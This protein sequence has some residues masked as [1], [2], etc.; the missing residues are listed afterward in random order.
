MS[1]IKLLADFSKAAYNITHKFH[2]ED[3]TINDPS[4]HSAEAFND[5]LKQGWAPLKFTTLSPSINS[6]GYINFGMTDDGMFI[7]GNAAVFAAR[8]GDSIVL[9]F[10]G[11]NDAAKEGENPYDP[12]DLK[13]PD[14]DQWKK[15]PDYYNALKP[16]LTQFDNY[17]KTNNIKN[18]YVTGHSM[19]GAM[20]IEYMSEHSG[21]QYQAVTFAA[22]P[23]GQPYLIFGTER[24]YYTNDDRITQ[25]EIAN[26]PGPMAYDIQNLFGNTRIRP[27]HV[28]EIQGNY[29]MDKPDKTEVPFTSDFYARNPN[30][31]MDYYR[32]ISQSIEDTTWNI[33][34]NSPGKQAV[35][36]GAQEINK[37]FIVDGKISGTNQIIDAGN[38]VLE[39]KYGANVIY[40][41]R[42]DDQIIGDQHAEYILAGD[43]NDT[44]SGNGGNDI[45]FGGLGNDIMDF[46]SNARTGNDT[47]YGG[48]GDDIFVFD[49]PKDQFIEYYNE[50]NDTA[51]VNFDYSLLYTPDIENLRGY[52]ASGVKLFGNSLDNLLSGTNGNDVLEGGAGKD[53]VELNG[54]ISDYK[55]TRTGNTISLLNKKTNEGIDTLINIESLKFADVSSNLEIQALAKTINQKSVNQILELYIAFFNRIPE[56][57]GVAYWLG[58]FKKGSTINQIAESFYNAGLSFSN[59]T[60]YSATMPN[61]DFVKVVYK[62]VLGRSDGGDA[63]GVAYWSEQLS[64]QKASRGSLVSDM[65]N[66]AHGFKNDAKWGWVANL[67]DN[68]V[69]VAKTIAI[70]F[71]INYSSSEAAIRSGMTIAS[72]ITDTDIN[73]ALS[74][75]GVSSLDV[76]L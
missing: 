15:M 33:L 44:I 32:Q 56:A 20:A 45:V 37:Q 41:G 7:N 3:P 4:P 12:L 74:I 49:S 72:Y 59:L 25:I 69:T 75:I 54:K 24:K 67:L 11:T 39:S 31:S 55:I 52:G 26:D 8:Q 10:R 61:S 43:G 29:T 22:T 9:A 28:I 23:F 19:G 13:H 58:E 71:G 63:S 66:S 50:G 1:L 46:S 14:K 38:N 76:M 73:V 47:F 64:T 2:K 40:A 36:I 60:G 68:K 48:L 27:G 65:L 51:W 53:T 6:S 57:D 42:G 35:F 16:F 62:N 21:T 70:D 30:H 17:V 18:V 34:L 5:I